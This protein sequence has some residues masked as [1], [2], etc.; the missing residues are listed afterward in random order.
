MYVQFMSYVYWIDGCFEWQECWSS[1][2]WRCRNTVVAVYVLRK[3]DIEKTAVRVYLPHLTFW[4]PKSCATKVAEIAFIG[5]SVHYSIKFIRRN[6]KSSNNMCNSILCT[7]EIYGLKCVAAC[8]QCR[9]EI[10][11][12]SEVIA[13]KKQWASF[14]VCELIT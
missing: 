9:G 14:H 2:S 12:N 7:C 13:V 4:M 5:I 1:R 3:S 10:C 8:G 6:R 11:E